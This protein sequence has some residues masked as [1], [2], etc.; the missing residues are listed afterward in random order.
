MKR[1]SLVVGAAVV[2]ISSPTFATPT[3]LSVTDMLAMQRVGSPVPSPDGKWIAFTVRETDLEA[4]RGRYDLWLAATD[5]SSVSRLTTSPENDTDAAWSKDGKSLYFLS[6]RGGSSQVWKLA[7]GGVGGEAEQVTRL[8]V[9]VGGFEVFPDG[10]HLLLSAEVWPDAKTL[11]D[12]A[13]RDGEKAK[14]KVKARVYDH[15]L[16]RHWDQWEDGKF[17]HLFVWTSPELGGHP[18]DARDLM[19][20]A[21]TDTPTHPFGDME[22]ADIAPDGKAV[23]YLV[24]LGGAT[25]AWTTNTD[26]FEQALDNGVPRGKPVDLT[27]ANKGYDFGPLY[28]PDG[29]T[30]AVRSMARPGFESDRLAI[31]LI[32]RTAAPSGAAASGGQAPVGDRSTHKAHTIAD[33]WDRSA[34]S[35]AWSADGRTLYTSADN[36]GNTSL[37]AIDVA[38]GNAKVLVD[39][40]TNMGAAVAGD[41]IVYEHDTLVA[42][43]ELWSVKPDGTDAK[44]ITHLNDLRAHSIAWSG[45]EQFSFKGAHGDTVYGYVVKP[46]SWDGHSKA[47]VA[48]LIHGGPQGSFGDH[49]H[50]RWNAEAFAGHGYA[51][52]MIDFH[53]STGYG[54]KFTDA[55]SN[56]WA[57]A[58]YED[59]MSGLDAALAKYSWLDGNRVVALGASYGGYMI[60]WINGHTDRFKAL[61]VHDGNLDERMAYYDTEELWFPEWEHAGTPWDKPEGYTKS[62]PIDYIKNWKTPTLVIHGGLDFRIPE[63]Q[64]IATFTA[65][66]RRG[67]PSRF[68]EFPDENHWVLK[69][70]NS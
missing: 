47:P 58:P 1:L 2:A 68:L 8:P 10:R 19:P 69:P 43:G 18:D 48:F 53:G 63:T 55:I 64:G 20:G 22:D 14:S 59:L 16:F 61:V 32:D 31:T 42:P 70:Q 56:D 34:N 39:K 36:V 29:K 12:S 11:A 21:T 6:S 66:Q 40:G 17:S 35:L 50:Y 38:S 57:G 13:K 9:D 44:P 28:S 41:R 27:E 4:N 24:R 54:Q 3:G 15:L 51:A 30:L 23:A 60:N 65:L 49:F 33:H 7:I 67:V 45:Y 37:Y 5:G 25:A 52:I 46:A 26:V 62:N